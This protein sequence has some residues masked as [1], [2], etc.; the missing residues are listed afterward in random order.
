MDKRYVNPKIE[1]IWSYENKLRLWLDTELA[2]IFAR[3]ELGIYPLETYEAI[4]GRLSKK[5]INLKWWRTKDKEIN[6]D[7]N[8]FI[9]ERVRHLPKRLHKFFH[10]GMTSYDTQEAAFVR[11]LMDSEA[12]IMSLLEELRDVIVAKALENRYT[13]MMARTHGKNAQIETFGKRILSWLAEIDIC[14]N[15]L[16]KAKGNLGQAKLSGAIGNYGSITPEIELKALE[17]L[18]LKPFY[19]ATQIMPRE[20]YLPLADAMDTTCKA[21]EKI[22]R[23]FWLMTRD[24]RPLLSEPF[25]KKQMGSS[26]MPHKKNPITIEQLIGMAT[27]AGGYREMIRQNIITAEE[28]DI[29]Q[30]SVERVAWPDLFHVTARSISSLTKV[31][32][33]MVVY[34]DNMMRE[35]IESRGT[36]A[37][38]KAK[39]FLKEKLGLSYMDAYRVVQLAS[40]NVMEEQDP[41]IKEASSSF[42]DVRANMDQIR[43]RISSEKITS[44]SDVIM[45]G[46]LRVTPT[47]DI[48]LEDVTRF[49]GILLKHFK[50]FGEDGDKTREDWWEVFNPANHVKGEDILY[51]KI[52]SC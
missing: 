24:P 5:K 13:F 7:L 31:L 52:L 51:E 32:G 43:S 4:N 8:A 6:H 30:S 38:E 36:Y 9:R 22:A 20:L 40:F 19:G 1:W 15:E 49:N 25:G 14:I 27:M 41:V 42:A 39:G 35:I 45:N 33:G 47:L 12:E 29:S 26:A 34:R 11:I 50:A 16:T 28:R 46:E 23:D 44:I 21:I 37:S 17:T 3:E 2:V 18:G 10:D 48:S